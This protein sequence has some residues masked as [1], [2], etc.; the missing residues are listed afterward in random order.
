MKRN[1]ATSVFGC[2]AHT[3][4]GSRRAGNVLV[5][6]AVFSSVVLGALG[7]GAFQNLNFESA[8][9]PIV[10]ANQPTTVPFSDAFP[11]WTGYLGTNQASLA[12]Y[13]GI[14]V[15]AYE[16]SLV[17]T[18]TSFYGNRVISGTFTAVLQAGN[19]NP[20]LQYG[21]AAIGQTGIVPATALSLRFFAS[22]SAGDLVVSLNGQSVPFIPLSSGPNYV[23]YGADVSGFAGLPAE[24]RFTEQP[25]SNPFA[26]LFLDNI[27]FS[28]SV[29]PEPCV[30][31]LSALGTMLLAWRFL[32]R[33]SP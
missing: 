25:I 9:V 12:G 18:H 11:A 6:T 23:E 15:G 8:I 24:L 22:G 30:L 10:P 7:Q 2:L 3:Q 31:T 5:A 27:Q 26:T 16:I 29:I 33:T 13:N 21:P 19:A 4:R 1:F 28:T 17:D 20:P 14:S 32:R